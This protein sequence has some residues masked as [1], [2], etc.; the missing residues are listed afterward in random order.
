[1]KKILPRILNYIL[2]SVGILIAG[3]G[4]LIKW[5]IPHGPTGRNASLW[6]LDRYDWRDLHL[7]G[8][9]IIVLLVIWHLWLHR[10]WVMNIACQ[11][12]STMLLA[13]LL[14]PV[15]LIGA[16]AVSPLGNAPNADNE[17]GG[18]DRGQS[19]DKK[20]R[21]SADSTD[22]PSPRD[23]RGKSGGGSGK[24]RKKGAGTETEH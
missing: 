18:D 7:W 11:K 9:I 2:Y 5:K 12:H 14:A 3:S 15:I 17:C 23:G 6:G 24:H 8:G 4:F 13:G 20:H 21:R 19:M 16:L 10:R 1:M 22:H